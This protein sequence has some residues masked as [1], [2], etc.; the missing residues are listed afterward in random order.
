MK[1]HFYR[2]NNLLEKEDKNLVELLTDMLIENEDR[3]HLIHK[4]FKPKS[5]WRPN[6]THVSLNSFKLAFKKQ[7]LYSKPRPE[8]KHNLTK[9]EQI[10]LN[11]LKSNKETVIQKADKGSAVVVMNNK[12]YLREGYR[13]LSDTNFYTKINND[14]TKTVTEKID[15]VLTEMKNRKIISSKNY[16]FLKPTNT[17]EGK[18]YLLPKIHK[19]GIPG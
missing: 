12:D 13:Q 19:K 18:F 1:H 5:N 8:T 14:P 7:L 10:G 9:E 2:D 15:T 11:Q 4:Q 6:N 3:H 16:D 17:K